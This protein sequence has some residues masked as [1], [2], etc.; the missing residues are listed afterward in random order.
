MRYIHHSPSILKA[1]AL[2]IGNI[3]NDAHLVE[4]CLEGDYRAYAALVDRYRYPVFGL[5]LSY[6]KDFDAAEDAAQEALINAYLKLESLPEPQSFGPWLRTIAANYCRMW[7]RRQRRQVCFDEERAPADPALSPAAQVLVRERRQQVL[8]AVARL[9]RVQQQA[10]VLFYLED[11]SLAQIAAFLEVSVATVEQRLYRARRRLKE[12]MLNMV[13]ENLQDHHLPADFTREIMAEALSRGE[14]LLTERSWSQARKAFNRVAAA[15]P[16]HREAHRGLALAF[17]GETREALKSENGHFADDRLL[18]DTFAA[19]HKAYE[20][21]ADDEMIIRSI[22]RLYSHWGRHRE[23]GEFLEAAASRIDDWQQSVP[24]YGMAIAVYYHAHY[25]DRGD[26][27]EA[28]VRCHR[29]RRELVPADWPARRRF[30]VWQ[31]GDM[32][33]AYAHLGLSQE[34]FDELGALR[35]EIEPEWSVEEYF[36]YTGICSNQHREVGQWEEVEQYSR[37]FVDWAKALSA[38]DPR[39]EIKPVSLTEEGDAREGLHAGD[40][41][42]WWTVC[43][44]LSSR[45][46]RAR[47]EM[48]GDSAAILAELDWVLA[49]HE[50]HCRPIGERAAENPQDPD[51]W[52]W[53][54]GSYAIAGESACETEHYEEAVRYLSREEELSGQN[55]GRGELYL[56][57]ALVAL[58]QVDEG[59]ERLRTI[60]GRNLA[61]A[62]AD[63]PK[64]PRAPE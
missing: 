38:D 56:A 61:C 23:G 8:A 34:V 44:A 11:L 1:S 12:E 17:D 37:E 15:V 57:G 39:I 28:C 2:K 46:L 6:V 63:S 21:G 7:L 4:A 40:A 33:L 3:V 52:P 58:G 10:V 45:I 20:L 16:D 32:S 36:Q 62:P 47:S 9:S 50:A 27:M 54:P 43:H 24:L 51:L 25:T 53:L 30:N 48:R 64:Y 55:V 26:N 14:Q 49:Q 13:E 42:R 18:D 19:L 29:R 22:G 35:G 59:K 60:Y 5:C 41:F 31:P